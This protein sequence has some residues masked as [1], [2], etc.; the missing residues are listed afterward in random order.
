MSDYRREQLLTYIGGPFLVLVG[1]YLMYRS[2]NYL[3][4]VSAPGHIGMG[5]MNAVVGPVVLSYG[6]Y[7]FRT[8]RRLLASDHW[9]AEHFIP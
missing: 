1:L 9:R 7:V 8:G 5:I 3:C 6:V 4:F 2:V